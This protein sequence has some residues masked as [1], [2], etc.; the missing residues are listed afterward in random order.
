[1]KIFW[2]IN[3][4]EEEK[5]ALDNVDCKKKKKIGTSLQLYQCDAQLMILNFGLNF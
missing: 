4:K 2:N 1:M 5:L 3:G